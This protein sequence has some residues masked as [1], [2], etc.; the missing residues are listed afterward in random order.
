MK[1][2]SPTLDMMGVLSQLDALRIARVSASANE[3]G[4]SMV[5]SAKTFIEFAHDCASG[6]PWQR[7]DSLSPY[8]VY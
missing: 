2:P 8:Q 4:L 7:G 6:P 1:H 3:L 5:Q